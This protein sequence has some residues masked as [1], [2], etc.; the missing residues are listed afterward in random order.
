MASTPSLKGWLKTTALPLPTDEA[1]DKF[2][3]LVISGKVGEELVHAYKYV[4]SL[5]KLEPAGITCG[6]RELAEVKKLIADNPE[7]VMFSATLSQLCVDER[8]LSTI[9]FG[10]LAYLIETAD[11]DWRLKSMMGAITVN[12]EDGEQLTFRRLNKDAEVDALC[13]LLFWN[14]TNSEI[15]SRLIAIASDL[16][17]L[18]RRLGQ[19]SNV[20][21]EIMN[22]REN[23]RQAMAVSAWRKC[24]FLQEYCDRVIK[25]EWS[26][27]E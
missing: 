13:L 16:V 2:Q 5:P 3:K 26:T 8:A 10:R 25:E 7:G 12:I 14:N 27:D 19:G 6:I 11:S 15:K 20:F 22:A 24:I 23:S 17:F 4:E 18:G 21:F 9:D 1:A